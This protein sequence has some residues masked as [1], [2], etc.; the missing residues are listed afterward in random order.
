[1]N[2]A[3]LLDLSLEVLLFIFHCEFLS[4]DV[5][6]QCRLICGNSSKNPAGFGGSLRTR[7]SCE[8][9]ENRSKKS[10][11]FSFDLILLLIFC[12]GFM[13]QNNSINMLVVFSELV[14]GE[15]RVGGGGEAAGAVQR[16]V[17]RLQDLLEM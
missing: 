1:M 5:Y 17:S 16:R 14:E 10:V 3:S 15:R 2:D 8:S 4:E 9:A 11:L 13:I 12:S 6:L 7:R